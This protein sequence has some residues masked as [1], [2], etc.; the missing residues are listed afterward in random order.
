M[1]NLTSNSEA[2]S[3]AMTELTDEDHVGAKCDEC[4]RIKGQ[5][6]LE[7]DV[8]PEVGWMVCTALRGETVTQ[9]KHVC[10]WCWDDFLATMEAVEDQSV[11]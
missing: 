3:W 5:E 2:R 10:P 8:V 9:V 6:N 11:Q 4:G 7:V 1:E